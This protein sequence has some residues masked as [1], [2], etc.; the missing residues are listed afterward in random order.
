M[1]IRTL[2]SKVQ[3]GGFFYAQ[4]DK[5]IVTD[6]IFYMVGKQIMYSYDINSHPALFIEVLE[7]SQVLHHRH[8]SDK[9]EQEG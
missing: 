6:R 1:E 2:W 8:I 3:L 5:V 9:K 4:H 7:N